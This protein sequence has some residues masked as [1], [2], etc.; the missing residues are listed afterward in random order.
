MFA[1]FAGRLANIDT[2]Y[3]EL[4]RIFLTRT[5]AEWMAL[6]VEADIPVMPIHDLESILADEH[7]AATDFFERV[8]HPSEGPIRSM[9]VAARWSDTPARPERLAPRLSEHAD[10]ILQEAGFSAAEI[11]A[12]VENAVVRRAPTKE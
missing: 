11:D 5:T 9:K 4:G 6:L 7:L 1:T 8:E 10:E 12:L 2:V 3:A